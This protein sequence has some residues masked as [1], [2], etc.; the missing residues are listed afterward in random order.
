MFTGKSAQQL[1][2]AGR[3]LK[4]SFKQEVKPPIKETELK[5]CVAPIVATEQFKLILRSVYAPF[6]SSY[7][8]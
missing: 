7:L 4:T 1:P 2:F 3:S 6:N 5:P 8:S